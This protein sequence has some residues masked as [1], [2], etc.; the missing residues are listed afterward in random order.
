ML[1]AIHVQPEALNSQRDRQGARAQDS[2][3]WE[4]LKD[5]GLFCLGVELGPSQQ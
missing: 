1:E 2:V 3:L 4:Y 5:Q